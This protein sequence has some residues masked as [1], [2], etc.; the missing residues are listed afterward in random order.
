[1]TSA[2]KGNQACVE[3]TR[4]R[5]LASLLMWLAHITFAANALAQEPARIALLIGNQ[6]YNSAVGRLTTPHQDVE[7]VGAALRQL[8]FD[9]TPIK[10]ASYQQMDAAIRRYADRLRDAGSGAIGF[11]YYS[12]HGLANPDNNANYLVPVDMLRA[13]T[14]DIWYASL[15]QSAIID[16]LKNRAGNARHIAVFDACRDELNL[17]RAGRKALGAQKGFVPI[18]EMRGM[19]IAYA[20][21]EKQ[22][23]AD[24]GIFAKI[25]AEE[26]VKPGVEAVAM[27]RAVQLRAAREMNQEP[28][29][30]LHYLPQTFL[31]GQSPPW[32]PG[33]PRQECTASRLEEIEISSS[34]QDIRMFNNHCCSVGT[35]G[36][37]LCQQS[38]LLEGRISGA[39]LTG[40]AFCLS[41]YIEGIPQKN[42]LGPALTIAFDNNTTSLTSIAE[43]ALRDFVSDHRNDRRVSLRIVGHANRTGLRTYNQQLSKQR[44]EAVE[45]YLK[46]KLQALIGS[47]QIVT[48]GKGWDLPLEGLEEENGLQR[49]VE[50][51]VQRARQ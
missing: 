17:T 15:E 37:K 49:R 18:G 48:E 39:P 28:W 13:D 50:I 44:A 23:A 31:A 6:G 34:W 22:T 46:P 11:F 2:A 19:L 9:V 3:D 12:G 38:A 29:M 4:L 25:L 24:T 1:M 5:V 30:S 20:T 40:K 7:V 35:S 47:L 51:S 26:M 45:E 14:Q 41:M 42:C 32:P 33:P 27:F 21:A 8:G 10:D 16:R 43:T 36:N